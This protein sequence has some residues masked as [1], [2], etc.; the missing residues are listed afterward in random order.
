MIKIDNITCQKCILA[1]VTKHINHDFKHKKRDLQYLKLVRSNLF[2]SIQ[3]LNFDKKRYFI[4]FLNETYKWLKVKLLNQKSNA[5]ITFCKYYKQKKRQFERKLKIFRIDNDTE[6]FDIIKMCIENDIHY[7]KI[8]VYAHEQVVDKKRI[9]L[10]LLNK[11]RVMLFLIKLN[12]RFWTKTL[13]TTIYLY[14]K[15]LHIN[16]NYKFSYELKFDHKSNLKHIKIWK[17]LTYNLINKSKKLNFWAKF[18]ILI[19]YEVSNLY[20]LLNVTNDKTFLSRD[21]QILKSVFLNKIQKTSNNF[22]IDEINAFRLINKR[23]KHKILI[24][25][26][27]QKNSK[28]IFSNTVV[29]K[30]ITLKI[31]NTTNEN[32]L[33]NNLILSD[34]NEKSTQNVQKFIFENEFFF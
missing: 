21:V 27:A 33:N 25:C 24:L 1:K 13:L 3:M 5:K 34:L 22:L 6:F 4:I 20:K 11:I 28:R 15:T 16:V 30:N 18:I 19:K 26:Y 9:N 2:E 29:S 7:Q 32:S 17:S 31:S 10:T 12:K 23:K 8:D 14:N